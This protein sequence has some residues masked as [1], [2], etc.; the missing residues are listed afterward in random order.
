RQ[1]GLGAG[2]ASAAQDHVPG[3]VRVETHSGQLPAGEL[4]LDRQLR[5]CG[6]SVDIGREP[7]RRVFVA[8]GPHPAGSA[9]GSPPWRDRYPVRVRLGLNI[10]YLTATATPAD[11]LALVREAE[12][13]G[14]AVVW[15]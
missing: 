8:H 10:G 1:P 7:Q 12:R 13:L 5:R 11:T 6:G 9:C 3:P 2:A 4:S 14:Y 15:A